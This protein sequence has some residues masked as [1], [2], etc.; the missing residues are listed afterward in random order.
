MEIGCSKFPNIE[1][2]A[3]DEL[4]EESELLIAS[5][6]PNLT[7]RHFLDRNCMIACYCHYQ[8]L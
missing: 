4:D 3:P 7:H 6:S 5:P 2:P 8:T 1:E